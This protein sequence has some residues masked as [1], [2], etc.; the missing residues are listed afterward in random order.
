M[1]EKWNREE[2]IEIIEKMCYFNG[3]NRRNKTKN[4]LFQWIEIR[5]RRAKDFCFCLLTWMESIFILITNF[6]LNLTQQTK[7]YYLELN[8][9]ALILLRCFY[10]V[11]FQPTLCCLLIFTITLHVV[12]GIFF[13]A[14]SENLY[15]KVN[16]KLN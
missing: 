12:F 9:N 13:I 11:I 1:D 10:T 7:L 8:Y 5:K 15:T 2:E 3:L 4:V 14:N 16:K 6:K